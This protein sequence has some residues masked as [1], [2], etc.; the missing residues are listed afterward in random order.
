M[1]DSKEEC[2]MI[3]DPRSAAI[4]MLV[5]LIGWAIFIFAIFYPK[6]NSLKTYFE[7]K[8]KLY[9]KKIDD[10]LEGKDEKFNA[11]LDEKLPDITKGLKT[12]FK[13][14]LEDEAPVMFDAFM[15]KLAGE[16]TPAMVGAINTIGKGMYYNMSTDPEIERSIQG[17]IN[18]HINGI[19]GQLEARIGFS[20]QEMKEFKEF[21]TWASANK[22][23]LAGLAN[24]VPG[25]G[26]AP[27]DIM[28][29]LTG[30]GFQQ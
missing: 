10:I 5:S 22:E 1:G 12:E 11:I 23:K 27:F 30:R 4:G 29:M 17:K 20:E 19:V 21:I 2:K 9:M 14:V 25:G 15:V 16:P 7:D 3:F 8:E 6:I 13:T 24:I 18:G 28:G 26:G